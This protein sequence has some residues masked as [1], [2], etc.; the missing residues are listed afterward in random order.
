M[1]RTNYS[2][3][4]TDQLLSMVSDLQAVQMTNPPASIEW[5]VASDRLAPIFNELA[6]R[7]RLDAK[8]ARRKEVEERHDR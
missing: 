1:D 3:A 8:E 6:E 7:Q 2:D 5:R 4:T